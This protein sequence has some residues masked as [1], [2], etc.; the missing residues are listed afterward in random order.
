MIVTPTGFVG[1]RKRDGVV[2]LTASFRSALRWWD[3]CDAVETSRNIP[4]AVLL[5]T[6]SIRDIPYEAT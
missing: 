4:H 3:L 6:L 2:V 1:S 5:Q